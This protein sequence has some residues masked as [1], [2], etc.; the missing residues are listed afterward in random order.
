MVIWA[1][2]LIWHGK[3][4]GTPRKLL[5]VSRMRGLG[6]EPGIGLEEGLRDAFA[7]YLETECL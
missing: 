1:I 4:D 6:W 5:D 7:S 2:L 3:A